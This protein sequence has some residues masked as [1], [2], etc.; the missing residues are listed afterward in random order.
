MKRDAERESK[1]LCLVN[2]RRKGGG[3][4]FEG[5]NGRKRE[6]STNLVSWSKVPV[7]IETI[8]LC[9][10]WSW[11]NRRRPTKSPACRAV[12]RLASK[13]SAESDVDGRLAGM[14][15][16]W[17]PLSESC[18]SRSILPSASS[19]ISSMRLSS[20]TRSRTCGTLSKSPRCSRLKLLPTTSNHTKI[21]KSF[22]QSFLD[23]LVSQIWLARLPR[24]SALFNWP[25][26]FPLCFCY[27]KKRSGPIDFSPPL[28]GFL[29]R[30]VCSRPVLC[31]FK[32]FP[33]KS[34]A[35]PTSCIQYWF[36]QSCCCF[37]FGIVDV[38]D[39]SRDEQ[40]ETLLLLLFSAVS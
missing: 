16:S 15:A 27:L 7:A 6:S 32:S 10:K 24:T 19:S 29:L 11:S 38:R 23:T 20:S 4:V 5:E 21:N 18:S 13:C 37:F 39:L 8:T 35:G 22:S 3:N 28:L 25:V 26:G 17:L 34:T 33:W 1:F 30:L 40:R 36:A 2:W 12:I 9:A 14:L 31:F